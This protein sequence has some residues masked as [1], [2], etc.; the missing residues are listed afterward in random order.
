VAQELVKLANTTIAETNHKLYLERVAVSLLDLPFANRQVFL[1]F[2]D[3]PA[4]DMSSYDMD[5]LAI[6]YLTM[7]GIKLPAK[8]RALLEAEPPSAC[9]SSVPKKLA[10]KLKRTMESKRVCS[11]CN[12]KKRHSG[13]WYRDFC[14]ECA[15]KTDGDWV[16]RHCGRR[17]NFEDLGGSGK[18]NPSCCGSPC[19]HIKP[20]F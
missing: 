7:R 1:R 10:A 14:P 5:R 9:D 17:G 16:C 12:R 6:T 19:K 18:T 13:E 3:G 2:A 8:T 11:R 15:D 4:L 20:D